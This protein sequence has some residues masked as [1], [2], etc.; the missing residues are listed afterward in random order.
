MNLLA[1]FQNEDKL[2]LTKMFNDLCFSIQSSFQGSRCSY[3]DAE[4]FT[5]K[6]N[7][8]TKV[9]VRMNLKTSTLIVELTGDIGL[10]YR[11]ADECEV[12]ERDKYGQSKRVGLDGEKFSSLV[13][14][15]INL[16]TEWDLGLKEYAK[17][18]LEQE[19]KE[20]NKDFLRDLVK[21]MERMGYVPRTQT[22]RNVF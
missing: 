2:A 13:A 3:D 16:A 19:V 12:R 20:L 10:S 1:E 7:G 17:A 11:E 8:Q 6:H 21:L 14:S 4:R 9:Y 18:S 5:Y 15:K 22:G